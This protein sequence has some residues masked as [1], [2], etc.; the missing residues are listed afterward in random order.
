[1]KKLTVVLLL[2]F[3]CVIVYGK[4][5]KKKKKQKNT[6]D[7]VSIESYHT[8]CFGRCPVYKIAIDQDGICTYTGIMFV[9]DSGVYKKSIGKAK[10]TELFARFSAYKVDTCADR[11]ETRM[12]DLPGNV[13][14]IKYKTKTKMIQNTNFGPIPLR[15][16]HASVDSL[17]AGKLDNTWNIV[18]E[19]GSQK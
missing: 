15:Y 10:A 14:T 9:K 1:M 3:S 6:N 19:T 17:C 16:L 4:Q 11:Y 12:Q 8:A 5:H 13:L 2:V 7:I 18:N